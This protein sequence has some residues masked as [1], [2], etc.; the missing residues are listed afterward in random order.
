MKYFNFIHILCIL[1]LLLNSIDIESIFK[2][3]NIN[4]I[5]MVEVFNEDK[6]T[7]EEKNTDENEVKFNKDYILLLFG[8]YFN[9][10]LNKFNYVYFN[11]FYFYQLIKNIFK[12]PIFCCLA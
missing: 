3:K 4:S 12:P 6:N 5:E 1:F 2:Y 9:E 11:M 8:F 7:S 10:R